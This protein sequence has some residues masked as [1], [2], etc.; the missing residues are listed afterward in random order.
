MEMENTLAYYDTATITVVKVLGQ[1]QVLL[2]SKQ[3]YFSTVIHFHPS[4][5]CLGKAWANP[6]W[7]PLKSSSQVGS[8]FTC[9]Y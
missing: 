4:L 7:S 9:K 8:S 6:E 5:I 3:E 1:Q 2:C